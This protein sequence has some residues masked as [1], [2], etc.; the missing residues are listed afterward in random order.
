VPLSARQLRVLATGATRE[1]VWGLRAVARELRAWSTRA[2]QIPDTPIR[3][4][5]LSSLERKRGNTD[6]A[7]LFWTIPRVRS[8]VLLKLLVTYQVM[9]DFLDS[10]SETGAAGG[11]ENGLQLHLAL[12]DAVDCN[13]RISDYYRHHLCKDDGGYLRSLVEA[14]RECSACLPSFETVRP[15]LVREAHRASVQAINHD[16]DPRRRDAALR[17]WVAREWPGDHEVG[18]FELAAAAGAGIS[19]Y[20]LFALATHPHCSDTH[21]ASVYGAYFPWAS[22]LATMLDSYVDQDQDAANGDH[23]YIEHYASL[24]LANLGI[25]RLIRR[26]LTQAGA[27]PDGERHALV[28]ACMIA[29]YLSKDSALSAHRRSA[30]K[31]LLDVSGSLTKLLLPILWLWRTAYGQRAS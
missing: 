18:W 12:V 22:A 26:S 21:I 3:K 14:C 5:A 27:L 1:L 20:A 10:T 2:A 25:R 13:R 29:M 15:L 7:A 17:E 28:I 6:G 23:V 16:P 19:I 4:D 24:T 9:W 31:G 30:T 8:P 11:L